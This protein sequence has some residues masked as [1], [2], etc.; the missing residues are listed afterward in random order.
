MCSRNPE[1]PRCGQ[2]G[3]LVDPKGECRKE[4][5]RAPGIPGALPLHSKPLEC[6]EHWLQRT[7]ARGHNAS[8][9]F[10]PRLRSLKPFCIFHLPI[11]IVSKFSVCCLFCIAACNKMGW[12]RENWGV[13]S[14]LLTLCLHWHR[15]GVRPWPLQHKVGLL[16]DLQLMYQRHIRVELSVKQAGELEFRSLERFREPGI[17][18]CRSHTSLEQG[19]YPA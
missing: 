1:E 14:F 17:P 11:R 6:G 4:T 16:T 5:Q 18:A 13:P 7:G 15:T 8:S 19:S 3:L 12:E 10:T 9:H 2:A